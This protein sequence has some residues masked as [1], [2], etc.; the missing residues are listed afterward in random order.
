MP[1]PTLV[2]SKLSFNNPEKNRRIFTKE[3]QRADNNYCGNELFVNNFLS[4]ML[5][6]GQGAGAL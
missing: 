3:L 2:T 5:S 4:R 6:C 1:N